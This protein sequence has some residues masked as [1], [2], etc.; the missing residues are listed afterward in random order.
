[1][2]GRS[3]GGIAEDGF[4]AL[5]TG[6]L[7]Q[8][9]QS[10]LSPRLFIE[11]PLALRLGCNKSVQTLLTTSLPESLAQDNRVTDIYKHLYLLNKH[12]PWLSGSDTESF[13]L[14][15]FSSVGRAPP[16]ISTHSFLFH[17]VTPLHTAVP[18]WPLALPGAQVYN[19]DLSIPLSR[20]IAP[21][22]HF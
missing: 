7:F 8:P 19:S 18:S 17:V 14:S 11:L 10:P 2:E 1:M 16:V 22:S 13:S 5:C 21:L 12:P 9:R 4:G 20:L 3:G 15:L 6:S